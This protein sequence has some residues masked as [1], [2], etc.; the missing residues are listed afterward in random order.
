MIKKSHIIGLIILSGLAIFLLINL[1]ILWAAKKHIYKE[2]SDIP[3]KQVAIVLGAY[4]YPDGRMSDILKDRVDTG[5]ELYKL[6]KVE[7]ILISGDHGRTNYDEV[8]TVKKYLLENEINEKDIFLDHA[9]FDTYDSMYRAKNIFEV[10]SAIVVTQKFHLSRSIF[11]ARS[12]DIDAIGMIADKQNYLGMTRYKIRE[13]LSRIKAFLNV[14][15]KSKPKYLGDV[16]PI[17]GDGTLSWD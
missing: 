17:T 12:V 11:I 13:S 9:G 6:E 14:V 16:I 7:K 15:L 1:G 3:Q 2:I 4:V 10:T 5:I 8:N